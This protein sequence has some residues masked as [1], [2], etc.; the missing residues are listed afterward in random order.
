MSDFPTC[1]GWVLQNE[2]RGLT[3]RITHDSGGL[4][5][6]G[7]S[8]KAYPHLDIAN[9]TVDGA[10]QVYFTD[11][12]CKCGAAALQAN[13][14]AAKVLDLCVNC[15]IA[16]GTVIA[17]HAA[18]A[19]QPGAAALPQHG[20]MDPATATVLNAAEPAAVVQVLCTA[21]GSHYQQLAQLHPNLALYLKG[22]INRAQAVPVFAAAAGATALKS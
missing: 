17:L 18:N 15:G 13:L 3:G 8:Q 1:I 20:C 5:R 19:L 4:T 7:V 11:Y 22:W 12:W 2:D 16:M 6:Y 9:L 10:K 21:A 14:V